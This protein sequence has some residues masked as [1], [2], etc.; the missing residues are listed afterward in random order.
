MIRSLELKDRS[1]WFK[2][3]PWEDKSK[4]AYEQR[5]VVL[6][7]NLDPSLTSSEVQVMII[8]NF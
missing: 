1:K 6:F 7:E 3:M 2:A 5:R 4:T 8:P